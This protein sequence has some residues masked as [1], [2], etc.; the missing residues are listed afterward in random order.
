[1]RLDSEFGATI[2]FSRSCPMAD[3]LGQCTA[4]MDSQFS[5]LPAL[6][7]SVLGFGSDVSSS[8]DFARASLSAKTEERK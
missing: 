3:L 7:S 6:R 5:L 4:K 8:F 2:F 1:M